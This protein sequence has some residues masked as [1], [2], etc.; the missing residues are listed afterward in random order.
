MYSPNEEKQDK[1]TTKK[2]LLNQQ[3]VRIMHHSIFCVFANCKWEVYS[4]SRI[5][6]KKTNH[7]S[8]GALFYQF[9]LVVRFIF[10][11]YLYLLF[12]SC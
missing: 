11:F 12:L 2:I 5:V 3:Y 8:N 10:I 7:S 4:L 6:S 9:K 1:A